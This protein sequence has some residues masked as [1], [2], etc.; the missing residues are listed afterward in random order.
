MAFYRALLLVRKISTLRRLGVS[1]G[2]V[3]HEL[4]RRASAA[5]E[6]MAAPAAAR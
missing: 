4:A 5:L 1:A 2:V 3:F 6:Q